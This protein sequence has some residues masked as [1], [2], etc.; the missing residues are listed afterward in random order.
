[1]T[2]EQEKIQARI[3]E[4]KKSLDMVEPVKAIVKAFDGKCYN[5]RFDNAIQEVNCFVH[6]NRYSD[7]V[8]IVREYSYNDDTA[9]I[10]CYF[11]LSKVLEDGKRINAEK[12]I[13]NITNRMNKHKQTIMQL[14]C[15]LK[16]IEDTLVYLNQ[17]IAEVNNIVTSLSSECIDIYKSRFACI[18]HNLR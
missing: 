3:R 11:N 8:E 10:I 1:M 2:K 14:E 4:Y 6:H 5:C 16:T 17:K 13:E 15:A 12:I 18:N 7:C 9:A